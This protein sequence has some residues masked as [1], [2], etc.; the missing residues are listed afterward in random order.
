MHLEFVL[1]F[2]IITCDETG[3]VKRMEIRRINNIGVAIVDP[4]EKITSVNNMLDIMA[5][6]WMENC[7]ALIVREES[8]G[9]DFFDLKTGYAGELL[10]KISNYRMKMAIV[11]DFSKYTSK[12]ML[13][14]IYESNRGKQ[15]FFTGSVGEALNIIG[16]ST[17]G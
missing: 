8:L 16:K 3:G 14:L 13:A 5:K 9:K 7:G 15:V 17:G 4:G 10:Q 12:S 2:H 1:S 11:G 6:A